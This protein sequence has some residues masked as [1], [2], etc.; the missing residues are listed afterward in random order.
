MTI[1]LHDAVNEDGL[2]DVQGKAFAL[3]ETLF[4][5][6]GTTIP[7]SV[8]TFISQFLLRSDASDL[9]VFQAMENLPSA[10]S[11]WQSQASTLSSQV[12]TN[13]QNFLLE[14]VAADASQPENSLTFALQY[15]IDQMLSDGDY[16]TPNTISLTLTAGLANVGD[17]AICYSEL[18]G[19]GQINQNVLAETIDVTISST[20]GPILR[21][22]SPLPQSNRLAYDWPMGSGLNTTIVAT[23]PAASL[24]SNGDFEDETIADVPDDWMVHVGTPGTTVKVTDLEIQTV[25][26][27]G[28]P[29]GGSYLL[30]WTG[31]DSIARSTG[32]LAYNASA[33]AVQIAL[34]TIPALAAVTVSSSG[35]TPNYTHSITFHGVAGDPGQLTSVSDLTGG[36]PSIAHATPTPS[37]AGAY[38]G[39]ALEYDSD[40]AEVT[41]LYHALTLLTDIV[42]FCHLR[43]K[44]IGAA[45][46][47]EVRVEIVDG[48]GGTVVDDGEGNAAELIL[49]AS[50][51][52]DSTHDS[53]WF[54][55][56]VPAGAAMPVYLRIRISTAVSN[57]ASIFFDDV[58]IAAGTRL[59]AGGPYVAAFAGGTVSHPNDLWELAVVNDRA[60]EIQEWY[61]RV[62]DMA[63]K[64]LLL[65][66]SGS[67][68]IPPSWT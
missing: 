34:R 49:T 16:V 32:P 56:R 46:A 52:S 48:I 65:P 30:Q 33:S 24:L 58:A 15:L 19:D 8:E 6:I 57:T 27:S 20:T 40:G 18:R 11:S 10:L 39:R 41:A 23:D 9:D 68:L 59:Y 7:A 61:N 64:D 55:F 42:Y 13:L 50:A 51:I 53:E 26:I 35:T 4:T 5:S 2:F 3:L 36:T 37:S 60:G 22:R 43:V 14:V 47:G 17:A 54:S 29:T 21:L 63:G 31:P 25:A 62:F 67:S 38:R 44:R 1:E 12:R 28:S 66:V 45:A